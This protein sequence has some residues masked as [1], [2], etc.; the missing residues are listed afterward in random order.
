MLNYLIYILVVLILI[1]V[2]II[3]F[4]AI[5][6][7]MEAKRQ[8]YDNGSYEKESENLKDSNISLEI[9]NLKKLYDKNVI[10][11]DEFEL[12]KKKILK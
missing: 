3:A 10:T 12:A 6:R 4:K 2:L 1:F 7:G 11:K 5:N 8:N 9:E